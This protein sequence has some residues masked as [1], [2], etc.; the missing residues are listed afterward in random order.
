M[1]RVHARSRVG[2]TPAR[3][4]R[5]ATRPAPP[6]PP[7]APARPR[8]GGRGALICGLA[9][10]VLVVFMIVPEGF[11]YDTFRP[12][13]VVMPTEGSLT[14]RITWLALLGFGLFATLRRPQQLRALLREINPYLLGFAVLASLSVAWS[15]D[16]VV[17]VRRLIR[18][19]TIMLDGFALGLMG[20]HM[21]R[22]QSVVRPILTLMLIASIIFGL[23]SPLLAIERSLSS[24]LVGAWHGLATQKNALGSIAGTT[25]ILWLHGWLSRETR[26]WST[27]VGAAA[28]VSCLLLSR[29]S[30]SL[31]ATVFSGVL[32][33]MLMRSRPG[34][35]R[36]MPYLVGIF[37]V[38]ILLYSLAVLNLVPGL[39]FV[40][41]PITML[42]GKDQTFSGRTAIWAILDQHI[43][44]H[45]LFGTGYGAYWTGPVP[46]SPSFGVLRTLYFYPTEGHNGYLDVINDLG[47]VGGLCLLGFLV[48][49]LRQALRLFASVRAQGAL[50]LALLFQQ[51]IANLSESRWFNVLSIEFV[52]VTL[53]TVSMGRLLVQVRLEQRA[54]RAA[55]AAG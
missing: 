20:W 22:Y 38:T 27:L 49:Y 40:L 3:A 26:L 28:A 4:A 37:V 55:R 33:L 32:M 29:S 53:A 6:P 24:E 47:A 7:P 41:K 15:A 42:T 51:L 43:A 5:G 14:S 54:A 16:P 31:M 52:I 8:P 25:T 35:R 9:I 48:T 19:Y 12:G 21:T 36:Y 45:P 46:S 18:V 1:N 17:T 50:Y 30:T 11:N 2:G 34:L 23:T 13:A 10:W 39:G 44:Y